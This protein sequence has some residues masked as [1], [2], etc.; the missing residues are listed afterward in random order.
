M[1]R[2]LH[3]FAYVSSSAAPCAPPRFVWLA[4]ALL[5]AWPVSARAATPS[6][7][8]P[9]RTRIA[10]VGLSDATDHAWQVWT[11]SSPGAL[12]T[13]LLADSLRAS[14][15]REVLVLTDLPANPR[16]PLDDGPALDAAHELDAEIVVTGTVDEFTHEDRREAGKLWR[17][18]VGAPDARS[19]ARV[20]VTLRVLDAN[21]GSVII[22]TGATRERTSRATATVD[23]PSASPAAPASETLLGQALDEAISDLVHTIGLRLETRWQARVVSVVGDTCALDAGTTR[24]HF[25]GQRLEVWRSGIETWD[26]DFVRL[27]EEM[28]VGLLAVTSI[29]G[30]GRVRTRLIEG[31]ARPGDHV[32]ACSNSSPPVATLRR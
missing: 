3:P 17:W 31:E 4:V 20:K 2:P 9:P 10:L 28:R 7:C 5:A 24:G 26:E 19:R 14:R 12:V 27:S 6:G 30:P 1:V 18:G 25:V 32:R 11:G 13:R 16:R 8:D 29:E 21:D 23:R 15:G 22:E